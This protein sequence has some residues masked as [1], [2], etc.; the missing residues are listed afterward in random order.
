[1][2]L[3]SHLL[4]SCDFKHLQIPHIIK[5]SGVAV[6]FSIPQG[7]IDIHLLPHNYYNPIYSTT[8]NMITV[9]KYFP[10]APTPFNRH[11]SLGH[12]HSP[13]P[14]LSAL[15]NSPVPL[16]SRVS[17][18]LSCSFLDVIWRL[19]SQ[20]QMPAWWSSCRLQVCTATLI[21][22]LFERLLY[23][24]DLMPNLIVV[25]REK[26]CKRQDFWTN[27]Y[28]FMNQLPQSQNCVIS[29]RNILLLNDSGWGDISRW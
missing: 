22:L 27:I 3:P 2:I 25:V 8:R 24:N 1:M 6:N 16:R 17:R 12:Q 28:A 5:S 15:S 20:V 14:V 7:L 21:T 26:W 11:L 29:C 9:R 23:W 4:T 18:D 13:R 10:W 19:N